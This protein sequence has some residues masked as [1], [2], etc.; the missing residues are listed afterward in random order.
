MDI[1][2]LQDGS[3]APDPLNMHNSITIEPLPGL[4]SIFQELT[5]EDGYGFILH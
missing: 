3:I 5:R 4:E 2:A 1:Y